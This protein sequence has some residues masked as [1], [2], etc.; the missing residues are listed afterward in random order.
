MAAVN[1]VNPP[2]A[3][4]T[5]IDLFCILIN[6][7]QNSCVLKGANGIF[8]SN[9]YHVGRSIKAQGSRHKVQGSRIKVQG[10]RIKAQ[11]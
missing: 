4:S 5:G 9:L 2:P 8:G 1:P 10:S 11:G 6:F 7:M 3:M